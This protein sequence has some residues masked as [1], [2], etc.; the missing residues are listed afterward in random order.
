MEYF[1]GENFPPDIRE[2]CRILG[3]PCE[4]NW[5]GVSQLPDYKP[6]FPQWKDNK[7]RQSVKNLDENGFDLLQKMLIYDP[8]YRISSKAI[9][10][11]PYFDDLN[12][13]VLPAAIIKSVD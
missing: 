13:N 2:F 12:K 3:T 8:A 4:E 6:S 5:K 1:Y 9:I 11:H 7:L 10:N